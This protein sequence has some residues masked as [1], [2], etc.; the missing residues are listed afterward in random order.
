M[1]L[2]KPVAEKITV[3]EILISVRVDVPQK[4]GTE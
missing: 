4:C 1:P 2:A 3:N